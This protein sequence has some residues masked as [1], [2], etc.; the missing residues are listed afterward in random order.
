MVGELT[1]TI[2]GNVRREFGP[3]FMISAP[4]VVQGRPEDLRMRLRPP[5]FVVPI[6]WRNYD[7]YLSVGLE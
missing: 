1:N 3:E 5:V 4:M 2:A 7:A 6:R